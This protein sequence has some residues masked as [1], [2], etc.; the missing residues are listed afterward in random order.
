MDYTTPVYVGYCQITNKIYARIKD[1]FIINVSLH[2]DTD[3]A[4]E[5]F[6]YMMDNY[7][8]DEWLKL[9]M[10]HIPIH[11]NSHLYGKQL[12]IQE[13]LP[14]K[15]YIVEIYRDFEG[16]DNGQVVD[17][18]VLKMAALSNQEILEWHMSKQEHMY[19]T[20]METHYAIFNDK[21]YAIEMLTLM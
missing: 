2:P 6:R 12:K 19:I 9:I 15:Y 4:R 18:E 16:Y 13:E 11:M 17:I 3:R 20:G 8:N 1:T 5:Q 21:D 14:T 10:F 7:S